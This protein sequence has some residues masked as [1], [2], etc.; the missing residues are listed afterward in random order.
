MPATMTKDP[1]GK[2]YMVRTPGGVKGRKMTL[3]DAHAQVRLLNAI[4]HGWK[5]DKKKRPKG[6]TGHG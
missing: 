3:R 1:S 2:G 4:D 5:P 6:G